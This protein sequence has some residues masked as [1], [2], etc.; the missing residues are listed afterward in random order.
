MTQRSCHSIFLAPRCQR[1]AASSIRF[2][3]RV[4][5]ACRVL[6]A[7]LILKA[8]LS[9]PARKLGL[10]F[11]IR[12]CPLRGLGVPSL[13]LS[14]FSMPI[15]RLRTLGSYLIICFHR[16]KIEFCHLFRFSLDLAQRT[17][18]MMSCHSHT[19]KSGR[20]KRASQPPRTYH[21]TMESN[22]S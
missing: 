10:L 4:L 1:G 22:P 7:A 19:K 2:L 13:S 3:S 14:L 12:V 5:C 9:F 17:V 18:V 15:H 16:L 6:Q 20:R 8:G 11:A 21:I